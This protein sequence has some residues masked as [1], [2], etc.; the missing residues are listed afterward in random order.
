[1]NA[2]GHFHYNGSHLSWD[3]T[4]LSDG[5]HVLMMVVTGSGGTASDQKLCVVANGPAN[6]Q[7]LRAALSAWDNATVTEGSMGDGFYEAIVS[8]LIERR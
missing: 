6:D 3:T 7:G 5:V 1:M 8:T 4:A 2:S